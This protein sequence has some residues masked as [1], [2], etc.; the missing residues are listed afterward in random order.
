MALY[1]DEGA[2]CL[3][4]GPVFYWI[5]GDMIIYSIHKELVLFG[6]VHIKWLTPFCTLAVP[7]TTL[8]TISIG[9][10]LFSI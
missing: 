7:H 10:L 5:R 4:L 8:Y 2:L 9:F 6:S 3:C 1:Y